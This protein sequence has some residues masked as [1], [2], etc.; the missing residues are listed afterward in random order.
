MPET[1]RADG[2]YWTRTARTRQFPV[3]EGSIEVDVAIIGGGIVGAIAA[4]LLKDRGVTVA[5]V[6][7]CRVGH[8]VTGRSTAKVTAQHALALSRIEDSHGTES[9]KA[10]AEANRAGVALISD[11]VARHSLD[12]DY[13]EAPAVAYAHTAE[14]ARRLRAEADAAGRAG[15]AMEVTEDAGLPFSVAAA[16]WLKQQYRFQPVDFVAGLA[17]TIPGDDS[18]VFERSPV[19]DRDD[20]GVATAQGRVRARRTIMATTFRSARSAGSTR[21]LRPTCTRSL[22]RVSIRRTRRK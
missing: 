17:A 15:L 13:R 16:L 19:L 6:E 11:L 12:C 4:R 9:A 8:G 2:C 7:A 1:I 3:L 20:A 18:H 21:T 22:P 10:Y 14:G 5:L